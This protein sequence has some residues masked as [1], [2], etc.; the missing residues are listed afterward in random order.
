MVDDKVHARS[1]GKY[2]MISQQPLSGRA[3]FG[4]QRLGEMEVWS[5]EAY[6][7]AYLLHEM[8]TVKSDDVLGRK[9]MYES[10][11]AGDMFS[12]WDV[13]ESFKVLLQELRG[14]G[15]NFVFE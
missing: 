7:A 14:V 13:P 10:I 2:S 9:S 1:V 12:E 3:Y 11:V 15:L 5:L 6:G 4:G 8:I